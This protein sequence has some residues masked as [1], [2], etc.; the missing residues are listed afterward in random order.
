MTYTAVFP[1]PRRRNF[2][3][4]VLPLVIVCLV[5]GLLTMNLALEGPSVSLAP[6]QRLPG[7]ADE[8]RTSFGFV[9]VQRAVAAASDAVAGIVEVR[10]G[11][12]LQNAAE[13]PLLFAASQFQ[14]VDG[15]GHI[16]PAES[17]PAT[18]LL[19][20]PNGALDLSY[21]FLTRGSAQR[22]IVRF[23]DLATRRSFDISLTAMQ[24]V[25]LVPCPGG[26]V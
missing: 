5:G 24:C 23:V 10:V 2:A 14:L 17:G 19:L 20:Q 9:E 16:V 4:P 1:T 26:H 15:H 22:F 25:G 12:M 13:V 6:S 8:V 7:I 3:L 11:V 21:R 18:P